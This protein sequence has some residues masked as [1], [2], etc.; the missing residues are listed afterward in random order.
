MTNWY[1]FVPKDGVFM[2]LYNLLLRVTLGF[3]VLFLLTRIMGRKEISQ[4]TFFNFVSAI[5]IGEIAASLVV[6]PE[7]SIR[8]GIIALAGW[9]FFTLLMGYVDIKSISA[10]KLLVGEPVILIKEGKIMEQSL[11]KSRLDLDSLRAMLR[12]KDVFSMEEVEY[13]I[14]ETNGTLSVMKKHTQ[15]SLTKGDMKVEKKKVFTLPT[16]VVL[17]GNIITEN[18]EKLDLTTEWLLQ[19]L[20]TAGIK[21]AS[22]VFYAEI[23]QDGTLYI[24]NKVH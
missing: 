19:E 17:D 16:G 1:L 13:A 6:D 5:A 11:R 18:L 12:E 14:F 7:L 20:Q 8:N 2:E 22:D 24:D 3:L 23:Q 9:S 21:S 10:R 4:M 15:Q